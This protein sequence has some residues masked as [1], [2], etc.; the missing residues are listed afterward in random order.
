MRTA[1]VTTETTT[2]PTTGAAT[3]ATTVTAATAATT[4]T[5][6]TA[7]TATLVPAQRRSHFFFG[8]TLPISLVIDTFI[9]KF[10]STKWQKVI[11][12]ERQF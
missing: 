6:A 10:T 4:V 9:E 12:P 11:L 3:A 5:A 1:A 8:R 2:P 7:A